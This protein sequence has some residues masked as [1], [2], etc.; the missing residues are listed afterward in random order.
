M[1]VQ[2]NYLWMLCAFAFYGLLCLLEELFGWLR[3]RRR[4]LPAIRLVLLFRNNEDTVEWFI[5]RLHRVLHMEGRAIISEVFFVDVN[6]QDNT[7]LILERLSNNHHLFSYIA[8]DRTTILKETGNSLVIDC[9][10]ADWT[11]CL[12][13]INLLLSGSRRETA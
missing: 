6:S 1:F 9:R 5:R 3:D 12:K 4:A 11:K 2:G 7:P 13:Q 8:S 10:H